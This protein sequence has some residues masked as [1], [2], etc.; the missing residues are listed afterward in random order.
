MNHDDLDTML[1]NVVNNGAK[2]A[3]DF[4]V[5]HAFFVLFGDERTSKFDDNASHHDA[6]KKLTFMSMPTK[7]RIQ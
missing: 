3:N 5:C 1:C 6:A 4:D 7:H 2:V